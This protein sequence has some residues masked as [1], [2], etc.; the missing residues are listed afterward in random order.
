M[1]PDGPRPPLSGKSQPCFVAN[2]FLGRLPFAV[3]SQPCV[4]GDAAVILTSGFKPL[5]GPSPRRM[6][7]LAFPE[8]VS[9]YSGATVPDFHGIP[10]APSPCF[11][12]PTRSSFWNAERDGT[13][14]RTGLIQANSC[15]DA[16]HFSS[17]V[18]TPTGQRESL[19]D[20]IGRH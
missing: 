5:P 15:G 14:Q 1:D 3:G 17:K 20:L 19:K 18:L 11:P 10:C 16:I 4:E 2:K 13:T 9:R 7:G 8:I 12:I 6:S